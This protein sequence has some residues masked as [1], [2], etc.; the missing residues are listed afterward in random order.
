MPFGREFYHFTTEPF[1]QYLLGIGHLSLTES[2]IGAPDVPLY[3]DRGV[4][5]R[6]ANVGPPVVWLSSSPDRRASGVDPGASAFPW[7]RLT[8]EMG[9]L[10][11]H[12]WPKW[13]LL[14]HIDPYW[15]EVLATGDAQPESWFVTEKVVPWAAWRRIEYIDDGRAAWVPEDGIEITMSDSD[16]PWRQEQGEYGPVLIGPDGRSRRLF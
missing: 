1:L 7:L 3:R 5:P 6:G 12:A 16:V 4:R 14:H 13:S 2:N 11:V 15:A 8:V 9:P 10:Q